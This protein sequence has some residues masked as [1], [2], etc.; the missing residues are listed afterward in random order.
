MAP[1]SL[2]NFMRILKMVPFG[3]KMTATSLII[4]GKFMHIAKIDLS[5]ITQRM[6]HICTLK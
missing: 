6:K 2:P 1:L 4:I 5:F 3:H